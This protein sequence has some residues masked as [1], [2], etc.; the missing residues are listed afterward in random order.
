MHSDLVEVIEAVEQ[1]HVPVRGA[2]R[3]DMAEHFAV[4]ACQ[5]LGTE[6]GQR[7]GAGIGDEGGVDHRDRHAGA[8]I[9]QVQHGHLRR[10]AVLVVV[11]E[12][13]DDLDA[14]QAKRRH[15]A[16]QHVEVAIE[17]GVRH[18]VHARLDHGLAVAL[19]DQCLLH[20]VDDFG[21]GHFQPRNVPAVEVGEMN[22]SH[23]VPALQIS[24][25]GVSMESSVGMAPLTVICLYVRLP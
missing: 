9:E 14:G 17:G 25:C 24:V 4:A 6:R 13:A 10:Q 3:A 1:A 11:D 19:R 22:V 23:M 8:R 5:V 16:A 18:Q 2:T 15:V 21:I 7:P 20:R 12:I